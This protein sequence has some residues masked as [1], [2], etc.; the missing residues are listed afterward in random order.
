M[1]FLRVLTTII[2]MSTAMVVNAQIDDQLSSFGQLEDNPTAN[3]LNNRNTT[4]DSIQSQHKQIPRGIHVWTIDPLTGDRT[5]AVPDT[6][7]H[8]RQNMSFAEGLRGEYNTLGNNGTPRINRI[9]IDRPESQPFIFTQPYDQFIIQPKD[10][11]FTNTFSPLTNLQYVSCGNNNDGEDLFRALFAV[12]A[13]KRIGVGFKFDYLYARGYYASQNTSHFNYSMWGSYLGDNYDA[14]LLVSFNHQKVSENGGITNDDFILRP[15]NFTD[16]TNVNEM[17]TQLSSTWN[18]NQNQHVFF[19]HRYSLGFKKR[20]PMTEQEIAARKF[21][22]ESEKKN[23]E[24]RD[25]KDKLKKDDSISGRRNSGS[26]TAGGQ[27]LGRPKDA[28]V[29]GDEPDINKS[30]DEIKKDIEAITDSL[31][32]AN[33]DSIKDKVEEDWMKDEFVPVT[34]FIHS[35]SIDNYNRIYQAN[36][37]PEGYYVPTDDHNIG[38]LKL[39]PSIYDET[40][41]FSIR[42]SFAIALLEGFNKYAKAGLK[43]FIAHEAR[44]YTLPALDATKSFI[45]GTESW[46]EQNIYLGAELAKHQGQ[47]FHFAVRGELGATGEDAGQF[48][49]DGRADVNFP[50]LGD[51]IQLA[52]KASFHNLKPT[53]YYRHYASRFFVWD[54]DDLSMERRSHIEGLFSLKRTRTQLRIAFDNLSNYSYFALAYNKDDKFHQIGTTITPQQSGNISLFTAQLMQDFTYGIL[55]WENVLTYQKSSDDVVIAVPAINIYSN[56]YIKFKIAKVLNCMFGA[57]MRYYSKYNAM[58]Y[59]PA[60]GQYAVQA[61]DDM[62]REVGNYPFVNLY[63][64]FQLKYARFYVMMSHINC[65]GRGDYFTTPHHPMNERVLRFGLNWNFAN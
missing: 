35:L 20:V 44:S 55:N 28:I 42:N 10:F 59:A 50:L 46:K 29:V 33:Q 41:H 31:A 39:S 26:N 48:K 12:N 18:R 38:F 17:T 11:H 4:S 64:N 40:S 14:H 54:N 6:V 15:E 9:F 24:K 19:N 7:W 21:A 3:I 51:T 16:I 27:N 22:I 62:R 52:A 65:T 13:G 25:D 8:M 45:D 58:E 60:I 56:L 2:L 43:G 1:K 47:T 36:D 49:I 5:A 63:L 34:S 37:M 30:K 57:D 61:N 32:T 53:F 23:A